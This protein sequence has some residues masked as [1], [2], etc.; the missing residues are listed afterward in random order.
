MSIC[1]VLL[2]FLFLAAAVAQ[3][4]DYLEYAALGIDTLQS[5]YNPVTGLWTTTGWCRFTEAVEARS[6]TAQ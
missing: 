6:A 5:W 3:P 4:P 2:A 1:R